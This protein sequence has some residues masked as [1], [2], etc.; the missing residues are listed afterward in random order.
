MG[1]TPSATINWAAY[2]ALGNVQPGAFTGS[3]LT[4]PNVRGRYRVVAETADFLYG[5]TYVQ[6]QKRWPDEFTVADFP[7]ASK[8]LPLPPEYATKRQEFDNKGV[9]I[10]VPYPG[11]QPV[12]KWRLEY[13]NL[14]QDKWNVLDAFFNEH[15][16]EG[17]PFF[18]YDKRDEI[19]YDNCRITRYERDHR[20]KWLQSRTVEITYSPRQ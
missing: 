14:Y 3:T 10:S 6:V 16:G 7:P 12:R 11:A 20:K 18:F 15:A 17:Y 8:F 19:T 9:V 5:Q 4:A 13:R 2:D 1:G